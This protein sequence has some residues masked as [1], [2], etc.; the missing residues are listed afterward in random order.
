MRRRP[1]RSTLFPYTTLFRSA[2]PIRSYLHSQL[3]RL[4]G[5][6]GREIVG[7]PLV[8]G[9]LECAIFHT[10]Q[11]GDPSDLDN[12]PG[13]HVSAVSLLLRARSNFRRSEFKRKAKVLS[14]AKCR[15]SKDHN[16]SGPSG[17]F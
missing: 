10:Q 7:I 3:K 8:Y 13:Y 16:L 2:T 5:G 17:V 9:L 4:G 11:H 14:G 6:L 15:I 1:P 12:P